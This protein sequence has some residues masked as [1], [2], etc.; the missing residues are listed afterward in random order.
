MSRAI[1]LNKRRKKKKPVL[2]PQNTLSQAATDQLNGDNSLANIMNTDAYQLSRGNVGADGYIDGLMPPPNDYLPITY[3]NNVIKRDVGVLYN[4]KTGDIQS[5]GSSVSDILAGDSMAPL[6]DSTR[7]SVEEQYA[8]NMTPQDQR[9]DSMG[10]GYRP[11]MR[12]DALDMPMVS[13]SNQGILNE[14]SPALMTEDE[15]FG[16]LQNPEASEESRLNAQKTLSPNFKEPVL[17][18]IE[19]TYGE[20]DAIGTLQNPNAD[21]TELNAAREY[22]SGGALSDPVGSGRGNYGMPAPALDELSATDSALLPAQGEMP[23]GA[24]KDPYMPIPSTKDGYHRMPDGTLMADSEMEPKGVLETNGDVPTKGNGILNTDTTSSNDRKG[25]A[26][27]AN[28]RGSMMPF[29]KIDR[30]EALIR[31][32]GA[33]VGGSSQGYT[34]AM[35]AATAEYGNIQDT[36]RVSETNAFN[37]AEATRLAEERIA[38]LKA[39]GSNKTTD[40]DKETFNNV[41]SQLNSFQSG[42]DAIAQSKA[43]G[44]NL[45]GV[46]GIFKSFIDNYTGSPDAARRLLLSR[47][48]VDDALLRVAETKG[49]ISNKEMDLFLQPAPKNFQ[50]EKIWVDWINERMVALRNVQNRLNGNVVINESEQSYR[51]RAPTSNYK[52]VEVDGFT[53]Q[54]T[55][56]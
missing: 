36:N 13:N 28:A 6:Q 42:L 17:S 15:A 39:K 48:K 51:Y 46:G 2:L 9:P 7:K 19:S 23:T 12:A 16:I 54:Q 53:I 8:N 31:I 5:N 27:S 30:N 24:R 35:K 52:P 49:A 37:K 18:E 25:S 34:G 3:Y 32:G 50:D 14:S 29:A 44:G 38:A 11:N 10:V 43:E 21:P 45:T 20:E 47:L 55:K 1:L 22:F 40:K 56:K 26:V 33:M 4:P 41:S